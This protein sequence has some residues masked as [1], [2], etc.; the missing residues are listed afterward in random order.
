MLEMRQVVGVKVRVESGVFVPWV[1]V[2][3]TAVSQGKQ[4][5]CKQLFDFYAAGAIL[6]KVV[7]EALHVQ[8]SRVTQGQNTSRCGLFLRVE[9]GQEFPLSGPSLISVE[10]KLLQRLS[11]AG[12][13]IVRKKDN[14]VECFDRCS[15]VVP[16]HILKGS[17][18]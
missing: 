14:T 1:Q 10:T 18:A 3:E 16:F 15:W 2:E 17:V 11:C 13:V 7:F 9:L 4:L 12:L 8:L 5:R 6:S